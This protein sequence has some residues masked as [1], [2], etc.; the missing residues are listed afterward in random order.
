MKKEDFRH[1]LLPQPRPNGDIFIESVVATGP[2]TNLVA[3]S[4][5]SY[6]NNPA[7]SGAKMYQVR[8]AKL[9]TTG[10]GSFTN[11]SQG[12]FVSLY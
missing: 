4:I 5:T 3:T 10:S 8:G 12:I 11:L 2:W 9:I 6:T 7:P 1:G